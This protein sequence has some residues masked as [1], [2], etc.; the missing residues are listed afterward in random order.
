ML[1]KTKLLVLTLLLLCTATFAQSKKKK[2]KQKAES[3][4]PADA[5][6]DKDKKPSITEKVSSSKKIPGL[7]VLYQDTATGSV[8]LY[9]TKKQLEKEFIYQS[10]SMG[11][12]PQLFLNQNMIR[13]TWVFSLR[14]TFDKIQFVRENTNYYYDPTNAISKSANADVSEALFFSEKIVAEDESGYLISA[15]G[16]FISEKLDP[17]KPFLPPNLPPGAVLNLGG[18]NTSKSSYL[19]LRSFPKNTDVVVSLAYEN[20]SPMN[21]GGKDIT[22]PRYVQV[23]MQHSFIEMPENDYQVRYDDPR[24]G[25]FS[26]EIDDMTT[27]KAPNYKDVINRW[28]L[29]KKNPAAALSE[30]V[31]PIVWWIENTTPVEARETILLAGNKWNEAFEKAGFKNAVVMKQMPDT[32]TWDPADIRYNVIRWVSS[33]L[34]FAIGPSFVNPR[35]GQILGADITIDFGLFQGS[36]FEDESVSAFGGHDNSF[37]AMASS[38]FAKHK[39]CT[40]ADGLKLNHSSATTLVEAFDAAPEEMATLKEQFMAF[41]ILHEMGH[42][43]GLNHN[44][45]ASNMLKPAELNNKEITRKMGLV[46]SVM[47]YPI[48]NIAADKTKQGDYYTTKPGPYDLW[49]IEF[50]YTP[51]APGAEKEGLQ[52]ILSR[53]NEPNLIFGNDADITFPGRG[54]DPRVMVWDMSGDVVSY[55][56]ERFKT[57]N[58]GLTKLKE[59]FIKPGQSYE[60]LSNR[61]YSLSGQRFSMVRSLSIQIG[62]IYVD[63]S[64]PEQ[65][66]GNK[67]FTPVPSAYQKSAMKVLTNYIFAPNAFDADA[68]LYPYL[69]RQRRGFNFF[70]GTE[71]PKILRRAAAVQNTALDFILFPVTLNRVATTTLYGNTYTVAEIMNDLVKGCFAADING[72]VNAFR[73][74]LQTDLVQRLIGISE[75]VTKQYEPAAKAAAY[76]SL[77]SLRTMIASATG[78]DTQTK[79]HRSSLLFAIDKG[80]SVNK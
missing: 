57:V 21:F 61:Y 32:A 63:R 27:T 70:N 15:D 41:L 30:P 62:G 45:K 72:N 43:L 76:Y 19:T 18:L 73:Q 51:F 1:V 8:Q 16:L 3:A 79:A 28:H 20:P 13:E 31:E 10:F 59:K 55:S 52:K 71:D 24:V 80:L 56:E 38:Y 44:M 74:N 47:D 5:P 77:K 68:Q 36:V 34:G 37:D 75:D 23:K 65:Q 48:A 9:I 22:D 40:M 50:G 42:T 49:A 46:G 29:V 78:G 33:N 25:Y 54:I 39:H 14:K 66:S 35:T 6:K 4:A 64:F 67:P 11:G 58:K 53:S 2:D 17:V 26:Q 12:P 7:F 60:D 69:Q